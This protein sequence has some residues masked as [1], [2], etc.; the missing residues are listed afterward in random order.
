MFL[1]DRTNCQAPRELRPVRNIVM[2]L[3]SAGR[4]V[5][6]ASG[7]VGVEESIA[8]G[9]RVMPRAAFSKSSGFESGVTRPTPRADW[10]ERGGAISPCR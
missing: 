3:I 2:L 8:V 4:T 7:S 9:V 5:G 1:A 10:T 6:F